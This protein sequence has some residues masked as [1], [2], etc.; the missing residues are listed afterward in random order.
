MT[1][2]A[3]WVIAAIAVGACKGDAKKR[4]EPAAAAGGDAAVAV[5]LAAPDAGTITDAAAAA[6]AEPAPMPSE[7]LIADGLGAVLLAGPART[8]DGKSILWCTRGDNG[9]ADWRETTCHQVAP[10]KKPIVIPVMSYADAMAIDEG[11]DPAGDADAG[12][13]AADARDRVAAAIARL[14]LGA[15]ER[16]AL[17][18]PVR[19][20][21]DDGELTS[22]TPEAG[23]PADGCV[24]A[25]LT[26]SINPQGKVTVVNA[27][28]ILFTEVF[29][30][31]ARGKGESGDTCF[32]E[33]SHV[34]LSVDAPNKVAALAVW[35][36]DP[37]DSCALVTEFEVRAFAL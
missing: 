17:P 14:G 31:R 7:T 35:M 13:R 6:H 2:G 11:I 3:A 12:P 20:A 23:D 18:P 32:L 36:S 33:A 8:A 37:S 22:R 9:M 30:P 1:R 16:T 28:K 19:C 21:F 34:E 25:G 26:A 15:G 5:A 4:G 29:K 24:V 10:G 27:G